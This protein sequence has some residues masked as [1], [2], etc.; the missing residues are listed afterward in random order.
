LEVD[1]DIA[2]A[3]ETSFCLRE[4]LIKDPHRPRYHFLP[5]DGLWNDINGTLYWK[6]RYHIFFLAR[7]KNENLAAIERDEWPTFWEWQPVWAHVSSRD[8]IHWKYHPS[9]LPSGSPDMPQG[10]FSGDAIEGADRPTLIYHVPMQG[11]C[12]AVSNDDNLDEWTPLAENPVI[13]WSAG[14]TKNT[15]RFDGFSQAALGP[16]ERK[17]SLPECAIFDPCGWKEGDTYYAL[18]GNKNYREGYEGDSSSLFGSKDLRT[19]EYIGPFYKSDRKWTEEVEDCACPDFFPF[20]DRYMLL[21]HTHRPFGK[22]QYYIGAYHDH[23]FYPEI[24]GQLSYRGSLHMA[25]ETLLDDGGRRIYWGWLG[26]ARDGDEFSGYPDSGWSS[27]M[28]LPWHLYPSPDNTLRIKPVG[29]LESLRYNRLSLQSISL[30]EGEERTIDSISSNC[31]ETKMRIEAQSD[32]AFGLK[33]LCS[34]DGREQTVVTYDTRKKAFT[35]DFENASLNPHLSFPDHSW[36]QIIP[37]T[38]SGSELALDIF[39]DRS[40]IEIFVNNEICIVQRVYPTLEESRE[41][42]LFSVDVPVHYR[43]I[44]K[45][46]MDAANPW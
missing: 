9:F 43:G 19:W 31:M 11:T 25:P 27:V 15:A 4:K 13:H 24:N 44:V 29:E 16:H 41:V 26:E 8:L 14:N 2:K 23:R 33:L 32:G 38:P 12:I 28:T 46:E 20:G 45:W 35:V 21:M 1:L 42:R 22:S 18:V 40:V 17:A 7:K 30:S 6:G 5:A 10:L 34:P 39:V 3:L 36:K 37:Y